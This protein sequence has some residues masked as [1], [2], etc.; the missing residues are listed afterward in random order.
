LALQPYFAHHRATMSVLAPE[1]EP[2]FDGS[3]DHF[4]RAPENLPRWEPRPIAPEAAAA[5]E[6]LD[7]GKR[8]DRA[9]FLDAVDRA[10]ASDPNY[11]AGL[12]MERMKFL[13]V[14]HNAALAALEVH[15]LLATQNGKPVGR[16][17]AHIDRAYNDYHQAKV[18]W[19]GFF[20]CI[21]D[22][23]LA[24]ALLDRAARWLKE[25]GMTQIIGPNNFTT[26][27]QTGLLVENFARPPFVEMTYNP[28]Y[29]E[30]LV[31]SYGFAKAKDLLAFWIDVSA[32]TE[33]AKIKRFHDVSLKAQKRY[34][35]SIRGAKMSEF[36]SEVALLFRLYNAT[37]QKNWGFVPVNEAEFANIA[38]DL[39]PIIVD[40]LVLVVEDSAKQPIAFSVTLPNINE[41]LPKNGRLFP[42]GWWPLVTG[43]KRIKTA[44]LFVLGVVPGY[45]KRGVEAMLCIETALRAKRLGYTAGE[46]GWTLE[47]NVLVNRTVEAFGGRLDRRYRLF[48]LEL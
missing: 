39:K 46:I 40:E 42:F 41:I 15:A 20:D 25:R 13:D 14:S 26:N 30:A 35:L 27:H 16:I 44:R 45:R 43:M 5:I 18:G 32:G 7:L 37:W 8:G 24:H 28:S 3:G 22:V 2:P 36:V 21:D 38:R 29:Y 48:G 23:P 31:T 19:F 47:D 6:V 33:D 17:T 4:G 34:G 1:R 9:R 10:Q 11:I 12:R